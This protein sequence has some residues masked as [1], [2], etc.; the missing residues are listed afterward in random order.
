[1]CCLVAF[2]IICG[3]GGLRISMF[4]IEDGLWFKYDKCWVFERIVEIGFGL[5]EFSVLYRGRA[6]FSVGW[7]LK[8]LD[9]NNIE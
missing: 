5:I 9:V 6:V 7:G 1:M 8:Y 2:G 4:I 3:G